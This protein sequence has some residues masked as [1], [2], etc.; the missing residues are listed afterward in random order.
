MTMD[1]SNWGLIII[2]VLIA[3]FFFVRLAPMK[4]LK[5]LKANDFQKAIESSVNKILIDVREKN[6]FKNGFIP[7]AVNIPLSELKCYC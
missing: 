6:E 1:S 3:L 7:S 4:G 2:I 5:N